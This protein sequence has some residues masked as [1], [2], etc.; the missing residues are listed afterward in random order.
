[1]KKILIIDD[2]RDLLE[3]FRDY[4]QLMIS[5]TPLKMATKD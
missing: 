4:F 5:S 3:T 2:E 1:M